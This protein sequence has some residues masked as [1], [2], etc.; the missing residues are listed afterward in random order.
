MFEVEWLPGCI[1][2][3]L[4]LV[5]LFDTGYPVLELNLTTIPPIIEELNHLRIWMAQQ[6]SVSEERRN[7]LQ[8]AEDFLQAALQSWELIDRVWV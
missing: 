2:L 5:T 7:Q 8:K 3:D 1:A 4:K 6:P